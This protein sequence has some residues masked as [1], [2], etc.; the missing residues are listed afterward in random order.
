M[1]DFAGKVCLAPMVRSGELPTR[2]MALKHGADLVWLPEIV[3]KKLRNC[4]R[5]T[6]EELGTVDFVETRNNEIPV[7]KVGKQVP[8]V[9]RTDR[10]KE[11][12]KLI[13]QIGSA[14]PDIAVEAAQK[15][16]DDVDGI[17]LNCGCPKPFSTHAGMGA[18]L[19][20]TPELLTLILLSL[21]EKVGKPKGKPISAKIRLLDEK[22]PEPTLNL[23]EKICQTGIANLTVHCRTR[24]MRNRD[25]PIRDFVERVYEVVARHGVSLIING[26]FQCRKEI[27]NFQKSIGNPKVGGMIAEAAESN[28]TVFG[29]VPLLWKQVTQ[30]FLQTCITYKN[31]P[32][33][34]KYILLNQ[35][36]GKSPI[37][38]AICKVKTNEEFL[39]V[40][41]S[42]GEEG[43]LVFVRTMQKAVA[44][45]KDAFMAQFDTKRKASPEPEVVEKRA[46]IEAVAG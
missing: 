28:P 39:A 15:V 4:V 21:V 40:V 24:N 12:G 5:V 32:S 41:E 8:V 23:V 31:F 9:F 38:K 3:D 17:D 1:V 45:D 46:R 14:D 18:A 22:D 19:L 37:Y 11:Q 20:S 13:L 27:E 42:V 34:T 10:T 16:I 25:L 26:A 29:S 6:N 30:E 33:N 7:P 43:D 35:I 2:L 44:M 36:P